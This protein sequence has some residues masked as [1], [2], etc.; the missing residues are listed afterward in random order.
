MKLVDTSV[1]G[2]FVNKTTAVKTQIKCDVL[3]FPLGFG[4]NYTHGLRTHLPAAVLRGAMFPN[5][6]S[7][8][9]RAASDFYACLRRYDCPTGVSTVLLS[10]SVMHQIHTRMHPPRGRFSR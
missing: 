10:T 4:L 5:I 7:A 2:D 8:S 3:A 6:K 9:D 1:R